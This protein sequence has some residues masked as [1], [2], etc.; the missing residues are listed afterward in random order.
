ME[1]I[2]IRELNQQTSR[3]IERV[4][5]GEVVE[6]TDRGQPVARLVPA[7]PAPEPLDR[8]V[9]EGR[10]VPPTVVGRLPVPPVLDDPELDVASTLSAIREEERW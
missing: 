3:V 5:R 6:I 8:L 9:A 4:R 7:T 2:G 1:Q 10:V